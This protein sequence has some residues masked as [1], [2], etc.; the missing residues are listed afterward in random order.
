MKALLTL[1]LALAVSLPAC[2][3]T[4]ECDENTSCSGSEVCFRSRN[5]GGGYCVPQ[6]STDEATCGG[7]EVCRTCDTPS[8]N[9]CLPATTETVRLFVCA[10]CA[11]DPQCPVGQGCVDGVCV[12]GATGCTC[13]GTE[14]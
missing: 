5:T 12:D 6:C 4:T 2:I 8:G 13:A 3:A 11:C 1:L 7:T 14:C 10:P 9:L